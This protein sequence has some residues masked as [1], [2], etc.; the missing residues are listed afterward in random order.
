MSFLV[1]RPSRPVPMTWVRSTACSRAMRPTTGEIRPRSRDFRLTRGRQRR[2]GAP[3]GGLTATGRASASAAMPATAS[4]GWPMTAIAVPARTVVPSGWT[5]RRITPDTG[6]GTSVSTL[7][8]EISTMGAYFS[9]ESPSLTSHRLIVPSTTDSP[10]CG[11][12]TLLAIG[13]ASH[14][15]STD[16][17]SFSRGDALHDEHVFSQCRKSIQYALSLG[18]A[19]SAGIV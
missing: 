3:S 18:K 10:N 7:S 6:A 15:I 4:P 2:S 13:L 11:I 17:R 1:I 5:M 8:V 16:H 9:T 19:A 14:S 12:I